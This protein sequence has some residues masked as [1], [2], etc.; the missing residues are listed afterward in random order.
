[1]NT[2]THFESIDINHLA[3]VAGGIDWGELGRATAGGAVTGAAGGAVGGAVTG[4]FA[5]GVGA[6]PGAGIG[7]L[8]GGAGGAVTGALNNLGQQF[9][10]WR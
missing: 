2:A 9:G 8:A 10:F 6:L 3:D 5:G 4:S 7:A 1:M